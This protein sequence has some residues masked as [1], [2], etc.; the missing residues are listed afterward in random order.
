MPA[1]APRRVLLIHN[2]TAGRRKARRVAAVVEALRGLGCAVTLRPT[3]ARGDAESF[4]RE[5]QAD[6]Y[7][8]VAVAGGDGTLA[9]VAN[10]LAVGGSGLPVAV[11]PMGTANVFALEIGMPENP[12]AAARIIAHGAPRAVRC[13]EANGRLFV[14]MVGV[15]FDAHVVETVDPG[16]KRGL[17][18]GAYA[19]AMLR[20]MLN[21]EA[22][23]Y[24]VSVD[25]AIHEARS[26]II[27]KG[28]LYAGRFV[29]AP[30]ARHDDPSFQVCLFG[31]GGGWAIA[32]YLL[33]LALG[34]LE[35]HSD[36]RL[37]TGRE[38]HI[39][40]PAEEPVQADGDPAGHLPVRIGVWPEP[41]MLLAP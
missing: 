37:L 16:V 32:G 15:G 2:P 12:A 39:D 27:A 22:P 11:V 13:G 21:F 28:R 7:D 1:I 10:G 4:A 33:A 38:V 3:T 31:R 40:G 30:A 24:R 18:K 41:L 25:G 17:G 26:V 20:V 8:V 35:R 9:E 19:L 29:L 36:V 5:A 6:R 23:P 34:R 14:Q